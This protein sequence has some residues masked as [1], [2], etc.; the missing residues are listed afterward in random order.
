MM[1]KWTSLQNDG[2]NGLSWAGKAKQNIMGMISRQGWIQAVVS[3]KWNILLLMMGFLLGRAMILEELSPFAAAYFA[4]IYFLRRDIAAWVG[5]AAVA[6]SYLSLHSHAGYIGTEIA[7]FLLIQKGL[8]RFER[9]ELSFT[10]ILV[11][12][13][14]F[15]VQLFAAMVS[16]GLTWYALMMTGVEA[17]LSVIL[18]LIF[19][20]ALPVFTLSRKKNIQL[21]HE[22]VICL[23]LLLASVMTGTVAGPPAP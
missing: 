8:E 10:P 18:A 9:S 15:M 22:D 12:L 14:T 2:W 11:G 5:V 16:T 19:I 21:R 7:V 6:G 13:S 1:Q 3:K 23:I 4:V 20:Q 17:L